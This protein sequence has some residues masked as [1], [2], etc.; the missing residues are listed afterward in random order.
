M[1]GARVKLRVEVRAREEVGAR[2]K[3]RVRVRG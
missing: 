2:A 1:V 3:I